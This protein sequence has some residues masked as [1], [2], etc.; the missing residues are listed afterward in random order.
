MTPAVLTAIEAISTTRRLQDRALE[1]SAPYWGCDDTLFECKPICLRDM[2]VVT[3]R[4]SDTLC[5]GAPQDL[6]ACKCFHAAQWTCEGSG[7]VVCKARFGEGEL[8]TVGDKVCETRGAPK[9]A[10]AAELRVSSECE[11]VTDMRGSAPTAECLAQWATTT[12][13]P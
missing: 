8:Q 3:S 2:G 6:C 12:P 5:A 4:V 7:A 9:P 11:P 13:T 1:A 10:S